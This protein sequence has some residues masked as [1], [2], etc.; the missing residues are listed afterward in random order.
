MRFVSQND[1][2]NSIGT[3]DDYSFPSTNGTDRR[4][5]N[6]DELIHYELSDTIDG[7]DNMFQWHLEIKNVDW[8][9]QLN[10]IKAKDIFKR[11]KICRAER[12]KEVISTGYI[13]PQVFQSLS[14]QT[15][16]QSNFNNRYNI[17]VPTG[18][19]TDVR[20]LLDPNPPQE[21]DGFYPFAYGSFWLNFKYFYG[22]VPTEENSADVEKQFLQ[23][24]I[25][26]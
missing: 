14:D 2:T 22:Y 18:V 20:G 10:G 6:G 12:V 16:G 23:I 13:V 5:F 11:I 1:Y 7:Y 21:T 8:D 24:S 17:G 26:M 19:Y 3:D 9:Y 15:G 25:N 4:D